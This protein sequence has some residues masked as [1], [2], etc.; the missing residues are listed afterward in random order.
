MD[1]PSAAPAAAHF[2]PRSEAD[3]KRAEDHAAQRKARLSD[4]AWLAARDAELAAHAE[5]KAAAEAGRATR[6]AS[7]QQ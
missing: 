1:L 6:K 4:P 2:A 3:R 7:R 5:R